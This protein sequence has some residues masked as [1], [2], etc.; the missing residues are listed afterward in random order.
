MFLLKIKAYL[1]DYSILWLQIQKVV[2]T[3]YLVLSKR[4]VFLLDAYVRGPPA[5]LSQG[6]AHT[7]A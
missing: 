4:G 2:I 1:P 3:P 6:G 5:Y 7:V